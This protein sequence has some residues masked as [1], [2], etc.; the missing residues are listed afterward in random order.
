MTRVILGLAIGVVV[1]G[2]GVFVLLGDR[3][4]AEADCAGLCGDGTAC[5]DG[6]CV[7]AEVEPEA[8]VEDDKKGKKRRKRRRRGKPGPGDTWTPEEL[9]P[10]KPMKDSHIPRFNPKRVQQIDM[11]Q[12][13]ERLS[14]HQV[15]Q[16]MGRLEGKFND[17]IATAAMYS[18][19][20]LGSGSI[21]FVFSVEPSGKVSSVTAKAPKNLDVWG[22]VPC[23]RVAVAR[24]KFP[25]RDGPT[26][27]V[28][29]SFDVR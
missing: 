21:D 4:R 10:F 6:L 15:H 8:P 16:H 14:D 26:M 2:G 12:G 29:Y 11:K 20:D 25:A 19:K 27:G 28:D 17:C 7:V 23:M 22:I 9:P 5:V 24:Y 3:D 13:T 18:D 1:G